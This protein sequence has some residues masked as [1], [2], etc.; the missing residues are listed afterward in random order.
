MA[1]QQQPSTRRREAR[2]RGARLDSGAKVFGID[3]STGEEDERR[4]SDVNRG[5]IERDKEGL[6]SSLLR[7]VRELAE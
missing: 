5:E 7:I 6:T 2:E 3:S 1:Q 4:K